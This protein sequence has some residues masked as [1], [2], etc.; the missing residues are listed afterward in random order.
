MPAA[1]IEVD[2]GLV[3]LLLDAQRPDLARLEIRPLAFGWDNFSFR[4]G[5]DHVARLPRR[6]IA[7][8]LIENE[9][10][11]L[12]ELA[13]DL[14]LPVPTPEFVGEPMDRYPWRWLITPFIPGQPAGEVTA[15]DVA[16][17]SEQIGDFLKQLH[18]V[19]PSEAP[20]NPYRGGPLT[21]RDAATRQRLDAVADRRARGR[22]ARLWAEALSA[23]LFEGSPVWIHGD[24]HPQNL[25]VADRVLAGVI[26]FG[27]ITAGDPATDLAV[28]WSL[29]SDF[30]DRFWE[31][32]GPS[33][34]SL[35]LRARGWA[36]SLGLAYVASS[37]DN[38]S[39][40]RI[41]ETTLRAVL[42][43]S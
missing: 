38:P 2:V 30:Q 1:D 16:R 5:D 29:A 17:C 14:P 3:R 11:W 18:Q 36:I 23:D 15:F 7:A 12:P 31:A 35:R 42:D 8:G 24:L 4:I 28:A 40:E 13:P 9:A 37:A 41:G 33:G 26:D 22:L 19:A 43:L 39:M 32:Y 6:A 20:A 34:D 10:R 21:D 25:L 27:D